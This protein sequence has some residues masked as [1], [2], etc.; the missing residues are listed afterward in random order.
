MTQ[1]P[2]TE[3]PDA[4]PTVDGQTV[5]DRSTQFVPVEGGQQ[6]TSAEALLITAYVLMW[7]AVFIFVWLTARRQKALHERLDHIERALAQHDQQAGP[8]GA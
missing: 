5:E 6:T 1:A 3:S 7:L 4:S 8:G 2:A